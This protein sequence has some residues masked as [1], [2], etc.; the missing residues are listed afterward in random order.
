MGSS[1]SSDRRNQGI[2]AAFDDSLVLSLLPY[3]YS[4]DAL[5]LSIPRH[6]W[7]I[8]ELLNYQCGRSFNNAIGQS[9]ISMSQSNESAV[10][11]RLTEQNSGTHLLKAMLT[12]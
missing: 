11:T 5:Q 6:L 3:S 4:I 10:V 9:V 8:T 2:E 12:T 1:S 7:N